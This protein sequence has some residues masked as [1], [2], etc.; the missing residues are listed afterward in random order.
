MFATV[1]FLMCYYRRAIAFAVKMIQANRVRSIKAS[2][3]KDK[4]KALYSRVKKL[5]RS[6]DRFMPGVSRVTRTQALSTEECERDYPEKIPLLLPSALSPAERALLYPPYR[7]DEKEAALREA[8]CGDFLVQTR[9]NLRV[10]TSLYNQKRE[11]AF[12]QRE[13]TRANAMLTGVNDKIQRS[14]DNYRS[15]RAALEALKPN[16]EWM[17]RLRPLT[18]ADL[19]GPDGSGEEPLQLPSNARERPSEGRKELSWIWLSRG[20]QATTSNSAPVETPAG[21]SAR[22]G[23]SPIDSDPAAEANVN[24]TLKVEWCKTYAR[25]ER[26]REEELL[27]REEMRR[28][29]A[30]CEWKTMWWKDQI[31]RRASV[32]PALADGLSAYALKQAAVWDGLG[33]SFASKWATLFRKH[34]LPNAWPTKYASPLMMVPGPS[35]TTVAGVVQ[36]SNV[37]PSNS[38]QSARALSAPTTSI[39]NPATP[40][41]NPNASPPGSS[42]PSSLPSFQGTHITLGSTMDN[43]GP[44]DKPGEEDEVEID[45]DDSGLECGESLDDDDN[46]LYEDDY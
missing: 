17:S 13:N 11:V 37:P 40:P 30:Y 25:A 6:Q 15:A 12:G 28:T 23:V 3:L 18:D 26:W 36:N 35:D 46:E 34:N 43:L 38:S 27:V 29:L 45:W 21:I 24:A 42:T 14:A 4:R 7:L 31:G 22:D 39:P 10:R 41:S 19:K 20:Y 44:G 1:I 2:I 9:H 16:G 32:T 8:Q 33:L 5:R